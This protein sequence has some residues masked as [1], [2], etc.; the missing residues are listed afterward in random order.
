MLTNSTPRTSGQVFYNYPLRFKDSENGTVY[1]FSTTF[2]FAIEF[3]NGT[4]GGYGIAFVICPT[5]GLPLTFPLSYLG[6]FN[7]TNLGDPKNHI[8]AIELD[9]TYDESLGDINA[10]H[11]GIDINTLVSDKVASASYFKDDGTIRN[12][13][14]SSGDLMQ[15]W[16]EYDNKLKQLN[17][18]LHPLFVPKPKTPLLSLQ[19]DLSPYFLEYM[20]IGFTSATGSLTASHYILDWKFKMNGLVSDI[21]P[22]RLPKIPSWNQPKSHRIKKLLAIILSVLGVTILVFLIFGLWIFL[23]RKKLMEV[24]ED[25]EVQFGPHRFSYKDL[26]IATKGFKDTELL[27]KGGF[28]KVYKGTLPVS[29]I[30]IAV[31]RVSHDS[32]QGMREFIAEIATIG[33]L[34]HPNLVRLQGYCRHKGELY[35]VYDCMPRGSLDKFLYHQPMESLHW[36][37]RYKIIK[38][39]ASGLCYLHQQWVQVIIHRDI[40]PANI[41]LDGSMNAKLGDF[42]LAKLC[43]HGIDPQTSHVAGTLGYISPELSRTGKA[44]TNSDVYAFGVVMLE[45]TCGRK[46]ILSRASQSKMVLTDWVLECWENGDI[47]QVIDQRIGNEYH[48]E[49]VALVLKLG[50]LCSHPVAAIRPSMSGVVQFLDN[51]A[52]LPHNLLDIMKDQESKGGTE[53]SDEAPNSPAS[54]SIAPLTFTEPFVS[55]GR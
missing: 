11:V 2:V 24:L 30:E 31:K 10:N 36:S 16:I 14:L 54:N 5:R 32:R 9:T 8:V 40:K 7:L 50:L 6:L 27:G 3:H 26:H 28:G 20:Y 51:V 13:T 18:T 38:D 46:P 29:N 23:K 4:F 44:S 41:L 15:V 22:S 35:L 55:R 53:A 47:M 43:D 19:K 12:L 49:Q 42:G 52:Q 25:W 1:S 37:Q 45:I 48:E 21:N 34:R 33:R 39:V 17:V